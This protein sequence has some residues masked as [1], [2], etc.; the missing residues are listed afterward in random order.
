MCSVTS[1]T[2]VWNV[3]YCVFYCSENCFKML[4]T[5]LQQLRVEQVLWCFYPTCG[6]SGGQPGRSDAERQEEEKPEWAPQSR[7]SSGRR[8]ETQSSEARLRQ[9]PPFACCPAEG[10]PPTPQEAIQ[11]LLTWKTTTNMRDTQSETN[12]GKSGYSSWDSGSD[13]NKVEHAIRKTRSGIWEIRVQ[14]RVLVFCT[15]HFDLTFHTDF[16]D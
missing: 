11:Q 4:Q 9:H 6:L 5:L 15:P 1:C 16:Q 8:G 14:R 7:H 2:N 3:S 10:R 12:S 13:L